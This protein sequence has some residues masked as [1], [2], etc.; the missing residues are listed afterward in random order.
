MT[1]LTQFW[2]ESLLFRRIAAVSVFI[3]AALLVYF[4]SHIRRAISLP[5]D[6]L[7]ARIK[8]RFGDERMVIRS[9]KIAPEDLILS[10][11]GSKNEVA[12]IWMEDATLD[13][14]SQ[15]LLF[16][17]SDVP[18]AAR[19][20]YTTGDAQSLVAGGDTCHTTIEIRRA[21]NSTPVEALRLYQT[22]AT[23]GAQRFRQVVMDAGTST[24]AVEVHTDSPVAGP[25]SFSSCR[26]LLTIGDRAPI[27]LPPIPVH[28]LVHGGSIN[29]HF[30][31]A[32]PV[33]PIFTGPDQTFEAVSL[34]SGVLRA[35]GLQIVSTDQSA[36]PLLAV[37]ASRAKDDLT[38]SR[39]RLGSE[40]LTLEI[41]RDT[42]Q[43]LVYANGSSVYNY[44]LIDA[45]QK[46]LVLA[47]ALSALLGTALWQWVRKN[48][49]SISGD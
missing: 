45:M 49:F 21:T 2:G 48:L 9:P 37:K 40:A 26:K 29:L 14:Q 47:T 32:N 41:G 27:N 13:D 19:I 39:L 10:Y 20:G 24:M 4:G 3:L 7:N 35:G 42:E 23:A 36:L 33:L 17:H 30:Y 1:K 34:G 8:A 16:A 15:H 11:V 43:A 44:D 38:F 25:S 12:D 6:D 46:N 31:P 22:D 28:M 5:A 18:S